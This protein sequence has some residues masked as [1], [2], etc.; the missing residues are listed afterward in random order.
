MLSIFHFWI[1]HYTNF[2][3]LTK[4]VSQHLIAT[5]GH[6]H[7]HQFFIAHYFYMACFE[8]FGGGHGHLATLVAKNLYFLRDTP[9]VK[10]LRLSF[11]FIMLQRTKFSDHI[12]YGVV[13]KK[14]LIFLINCW[15]IIHT[16]KIMRYDNDGKFL[17]RQALPLPSS[18]ELVMHRNYNKC[19]LF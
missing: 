18:I 6:F 7:R 8:L 17:R 2:L 5:H 15:K 13:G 3:N 12:T 16:C 19:H 14:R 4:F 9:T 10:I 11:F 1:K